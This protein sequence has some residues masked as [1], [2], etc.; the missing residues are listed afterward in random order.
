MAKILIVDDDPLLS[1][2]LRETLSQKR[3][4]V[5][6][7]FEGKSA[8]DFVSVY[9]YDLI[10]LDWNLPALSGIEIAKRLKARSPATMILMLTS[11]AHAQDKLVGFESG[12]DDYMTKPVQ[13]DEFGARVL[14]LLRRS[15]FVEG[16]QITYKDLILELDTGVLKN[17]DKQ[18]VL[19]PKE[20]ELLELLMRHPDEHLSTEAL[21][22]RLWG[23]NASRAA[24]ANCLKRLRSLL[25]TLGHRDSIETLSSHGYRLKS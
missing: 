13:M 8:L 23:G 11:K 6:Q 25:G 4:V 17:A 5:E 2:I 21:L 12:V 9:K 3:H 20:L 7:A 10:I 19:P 22:E 16:R 14:A 15:G 24:L 18:V 1:E